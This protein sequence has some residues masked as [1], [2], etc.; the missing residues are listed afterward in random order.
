[1]YTSQAA[2]AHSSR[3]VH[4]RARKCADSR[5][6]EDNDDDEEEE[7]EEE[8]GRV[9]FVRSLIP[10]NQPRDIIYMGGVES[11]GAIAR[12]EVGAVA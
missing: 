5:F 10:R 4:T 1:M 11:Q 3:E 6:D 2:L 7:E 9:W 12:A 8:A